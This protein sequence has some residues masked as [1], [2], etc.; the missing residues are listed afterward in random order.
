VY[1][2]LAVGKDILASNLS[3]AKMQTATG[4][5]NVVRNALVAWGSLPRWQPTYAASGSSEAAA[6]SDVDADEVVFRALR[7]DED[8]TA[9]LRASGIQR[10]GMQTISEALE[11]CSRMRSHGISTTRDVVAAYCYGEMWHDP[12]AR[13]RPHVVESAH[14]IVAI[15]AAMVRG[16]RYDV[17]IR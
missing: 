5:S 13:A 3:F 15:R 8:A 16:D 4:V 12:S 10:E 14:T 1:G 9:G 7:S 6:L 11:R 17:S 2:S